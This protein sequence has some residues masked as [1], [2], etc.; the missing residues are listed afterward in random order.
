VRLHLEKEAQ[1]RGLQTSG[2]RRRVAG[3]AASALEGRLIHVKLVRTRAPVE[4]GTVQD[5]PCLQG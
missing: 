2:K 1:G 5:L 4:S 3:E